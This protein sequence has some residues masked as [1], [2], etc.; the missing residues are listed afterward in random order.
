MRE[1]VHRRRQRPQLETIERRLLHAAD[2]APLAMA[3]EAVGA[4]VQL[5]Q[6]ASPQPA[7]PAQQSADAQ[8]TGQAHTLVVVDG[9]VPDADRLL[10]DLQAQRDAGRSIDVLVVAADQDGI[11]AVS[12][13]LAATDTPYDAVHL[14]SHG[15]QGAIQLGASWLDTATLRYDAAALSGW[16]AGLSADADLLVYGCDVS[17]GSDGIRFIQGLAAL[18]GADVA[19]SDDATGASLLG[20]DWA[21]ESHAGTIEQGV[22]FDAAT[23]QGWNHLLAAPTPEDQGSVPSASPPTLDNQALSDASSGKQIAFATDGSSIAVWESQD[24][25]NTLRHVYAQRY[26]SNGTAIAGGF[27][28]V[29]TF[30][31]VSVPAEPTV[32]IDADGRFAIAWVQRNQGTGVNEVLASFYTNTGSVT[33]LDDGSSAGNQ[34]IAHGLLSIP[35]I[36]P[37]VN[38]Q[39]FNQQQPIIAAV[40]NDRFVIGF[41]TVGLALGHDTITLAAFDGSGNRQTGSDTSAVI[42]ALDGNASRAAIAGDGSGRFVVTWQQTPASGPTRIEGA[43]FT[44]PVDTSGATFTLP[45]ISG[46]SAGAADVAMDA[47]GRFVIAWTST[48]TNGD[49]ASVM[50]QRYT[51]SA[52]ADSVSINGS[53]FAVHTTV[54]NVH[55]D[56]T[57]SMDAAS[58]TFAVAWQS[59]GQDS[60]GDGIYFRRF[61]PNGN[62]LDGEILATGS[63]VTGDQL[64]PSIA[65]NGR[66]ALILYND[67]PNQQVEITR[68]GFTAGVGMLASPAATTESGGD[69]I[70][71]VWLEAPPV[72]IQDVTLE[73]AAQSIDG[74]ATN[75]GVINGISTLT[76]NA[77]NWSTPQT[78]T[79]HGKDDNVADGDVTYRIAFTATSTDP[80]YSGMTGFRA[81]Q[82][83][84]NETPSFQLAPLGG[85]QTDEGGG[86]VDLQV[87]VGTVPLGTVQLLLTISNGAEASFSSTSATIQTTVTFSPTDSGPKTVRVYGRNDLVTDPTTSFQVTAHLVAPDGQ[88]GGTTDA[89]YATLADSAND[90]SVT[91]SNAQIA[92]L[93]PTLTLAPELGTPAAFTVTRNGSYTLGPQVSVSD[94]DAGTQLLLLTLA[95]SAGTLRLTPGALAITSS[96]AVAAD[97]LQ[98]T[99]LLVTGTA[100]FTGTQGDLRALLASMSYEAGS[101]TGVSETRTLRIRIDD[102]GNTG[103]GGALM[104]EQVI[105]VTVT[106]PP[107]TISG[108]GTVIPTL[109]GEPTITRY[110][111]TEDVPMLF[112]N[113]EVLV[114]D[115][116]AKG[117]DQLTLTITVTGGTATAKPGKPTISGNGSSTLTLTGKKNELDD[118]L[119]ELIFTPTADRTAMASLE[120]ALTDLAGQTVR[121]ILQVTLAPVNDAPTVTG[122]TTA[123][124][125]EDKQNWQVAATDGTTFVVADARDVAADS[126]LPYLLRVTAEGA[127]GKP[128]GTLTLAPTS[129]DLGDSVYS[130]ATLLARGTLQ[131]LNTAL[132]DLRF[133]PAADFNGAVTIRVQLD[134]GGNVGGSPSAGLSA[135]TT[136]SLQVAPVNDKVVVTA[137]TTLTAVEDTELVLRGA[138]APQLSDAAD[139]N[140][141][142]VVTLFLTT[143]N[144]TLTLAQSNGLTFELGTSRSGSSIAVTGTIARLNAALDGLRFQAPQDST[145]PTGISILVLDLG[146]GSTGL[147]QKSTSTDITIA[148]TPVNDAPV[149]DTNRGI[150]LDGGSTVAIGTRRLEATDVDNGATELSFTV[151]TLPTQGQLLLDGTQ[152]AVGDRLTQ[153]DIDAGKLSYSQNV[154]GASSDRV[155]FDISD[156][157]GAGPRSVTFRM[158]MDP[159]L[160]V[161]PTKTTTSSSGGS[162]PA[163]TPATTTTTTTTTG[164]DSNGSGSGT[165]SSSSSTSTANGSTATPAAATTGSSD[166][167]NASGTAPRTSTSTTTAGAIGAGSGTVLAAATGTSARAIA[168]A[169][170]A[171]ISATAG[172]GS[173]EA[174]STAAPVGAG[175]AGPGASTIQA[176][177]RTATPAGLGDAARALD[178]ASSALLTMRTTDLTPEALK[179]VGVS[180]RQELARADF[181]QQL[182][183]VRDEIGEQVTLDHT[184][185]ASS[186]AVSASV[187]IG[188]VVWLLRGGLLLSSLLASVP[189]WRMI[190]PLPVLA[191][192]GA[193]DPGED[194]SL[195]GMLK[196]A[197][198]RWRGAEAADGASPGA[199]RTAGP[200]A[201]AASFG[202]VP[203]LS[204]R[205]ELPAAGR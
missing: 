56:A 83:L 202:E 204:D 183:R 119:S 48:P 74:L 171:A 173:A 54:G 182:Q 120:L 25:A 146:S 201:P 205:I 37:L 44:S 114:N 198:A 84:D 187:S 139:G 99:D 51:S 85:T 42:N 195:Q 179:Q 121:A 8:A 174:A 163:T 63:H 71:S 30:S 115:S 152:L 155:V 128:T 87:S 34:V 184:L 46:A 170:A 123:Q 133:T 23:L 203:E 118:A 167:G 61:G 189:A 172:N 9:R 140:T 60:S 122:P 67:A 142:G 4:V 154:A 169:A 92:N 126:K 35:L 168:G 81:L 19:A 20:G 144:G 130:G 166:A 148:V 105:T 135:A 33:H 150:T 191:G 53:A 13:A 151:R 18:T 7:A 79:M 72:G 57:L 149:I 112:T 96:G 27:I 192:P 31:D 160:A 106:N 10:A 89:V 29:A 164:S 176:S 109:P 91:L 80:A 143:P 181:R 199:T 52:V 21:L 68:S 36:G 178:G 113:A 134:D 26:D 157:S 39:Q 132:A 141:S 188:Y 50:A 15:Q 88:G 1:S 77:S 100:N 111:G 47:D 185:V 55:G 180:A 17:A 124:I 62:A 16:A 190:D 129:I 125:D 93:A 101:S 108:S 196:K 159:V 107:P 193:D 58:G 6:P 138:S 131:E 102:Q 65:Y 40:Q 137:P 110:A 70:Y 127:D 2:P 177:W 200:V 64:N 41:T 158:T 94:A 165:S 97:P 28:T 3:G 22:V 43:Y 90:R 73:L 38:D 5:A 59:L 86:F 78:V 161:Q 186:V 66:T 175:V 49:P 76:F 136:L 194:D 14:V 75:E 145:A 69:V 153:A 156:P 147:N 24:T 45:A 98:A 104:A 162:T 32:A 12:A 95:P 82:N 103:T 11:A 197:S 116:D 117:S